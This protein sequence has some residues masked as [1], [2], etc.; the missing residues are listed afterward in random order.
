MG[1]RA[2]YAFS[3]NDLTGRPPVAPEHV[4][5]KEGCG[6]AGEFRAPKD[7]TLTDY[8]WF[9]LEHVQEYNAQW[10][11]YQGMSPLE[12]EE[13]LKQDV[14]WQRPTWKLGER[15]T[16]PSLFADPLGIKRK[17]SANRARK[18]RRV[19]NT[20]CARIRQSPPPPEF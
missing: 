6:K 12:I 8:Y 4:C 1:R 18:F 10:D 14:C 17:L 15:G 11:Y 5:D 16:D 20:R 19:R 9:C 3:F 7:R 13:Q 2:K